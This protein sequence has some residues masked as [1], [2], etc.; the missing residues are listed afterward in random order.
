MPVATNR[1]CCGVP[2]VVNE[3]GLGP[4]TWSTVDVEEAGSGREGEMTRSGAMVRWYDRRLRSWPRLSRGKERVCCVDN[5]HATDCVC[6]TIGDGASREE[7]VGGGIAQGQRES[8]ESPSA[9]Y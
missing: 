4:A 8:Q 5:Q 7:E 2:S 6:A 1:W 9:S 3:C